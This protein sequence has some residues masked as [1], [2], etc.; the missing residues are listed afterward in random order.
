MDTRSF[1]QLYGKVSLSKTM[2]KTSTDFVDFL[3]FG[4]VYIHYWL[5][6]ANTLKHL[7]EVKHEFMNCTNKHAV[8]VARSSFAVGSDSILKKTCA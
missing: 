6:T 4:L 2:S 3:Q 1:I 5:F 7:F 8:L